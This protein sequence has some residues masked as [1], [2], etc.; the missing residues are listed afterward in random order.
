MLRR[1]DLPSPPSP[2]KTH[3]TR[4][5]RMKNKKKNSF[6]FTGTGKKKGTR[7]VGDAS[8]RVVKKLVVHSVRTG[9]LI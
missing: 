7:S 4:V 6:L 9:R 3:A 2:V 5:V 1:R 8:S